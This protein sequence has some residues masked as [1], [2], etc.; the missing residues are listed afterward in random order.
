MP[1]PVP[2]KGNIKN[3]FRRKTLR[4][5]LPW[6]YLYCRNSGWRPKCHKTTRFAAQFRPTDSPHWVRGDAE[7]GIG[8][9]DN[10]HESNGAKA[11]LRKA[12][13]KPRQMLRQDRA[14]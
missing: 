5:S 9:Q 13:H 10:D 1:H 14:L 2:N 8:V 11:R 4:R 3:D 12:I 6:P 7:E